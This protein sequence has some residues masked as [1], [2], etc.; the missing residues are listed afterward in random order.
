MAQPKAKRDWPDSGF[1]RKL[2][3]IRQARGMTQQ[4]MAVTLGVYLTTISKLERGA[5]PQWG[6]VWSWAERLGIDASEF[7]PDSYQTPKRKRTVKKEAA[8]D[9]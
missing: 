4:E 8:T 5:E 6:A 9:E 2:R 3:E 7:F 1:G